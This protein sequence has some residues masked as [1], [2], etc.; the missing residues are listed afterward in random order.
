MN[1]HLPVSTS[2]NDNSNIAPRRT[3]RSG[4]TVKF[5][6]IRNIHIINLIGAPLFAGIAVAVN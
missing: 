1:L 5:N 2:D 6:L 3:T 4:R